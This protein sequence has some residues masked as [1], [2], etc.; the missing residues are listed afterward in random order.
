MEI[1]KAMLAESNVK[2]DD[3]QERMDAD[4]E[5]RKQKI[6]AGQEHIKEIME[7]PF[8]SLANKLDAWRKEMQVDR[9][10]ARPRI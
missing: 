8:A 3:T 5:E 2:I 9:E 1:L 7:T 10:L 6:R 4:R